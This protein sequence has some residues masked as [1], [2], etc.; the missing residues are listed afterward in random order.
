MKQWLL[1]KVAGGPPYLQAANLGRSFPEV[2]RPLGLQC[3]QEPAEKKEEVR[4]TLTALIFQC[5][6]VILLSEALH[7]WFEGRE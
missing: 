7:R 4:A 6:F 1:P 3:L 5:W 2:N